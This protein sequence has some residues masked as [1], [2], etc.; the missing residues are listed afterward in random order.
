MQ[1]WYHLL[2]GE[3]HFFFVRP[4]AANLAVFEHWSTSLDQHERFLADECDECHKVGVTHKQRPKAGARVA[5]AEQSESLKRSSGSRS[6][7]AVGVAQAEQSES[8]K[9]SSRAARRVP[10]QG[11]AAP[12]NLTTAAHGQS[13]SPLQHTNSLTLPPPPSRL[14]LTALSNGS[15]QRRSPTALSNG[16][17][18][19]V[20][21]P[22]QTLFIPT[23]WLHAVFTPKDSLVFGGNFIHGLNCAGQLRVNKLEAFLKVPR[24]HR[25]LPPPPRRTRRRRSPG[26]AVAPLPAAI[27]RLSL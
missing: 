23:G 20:L 24:S 18:Q 1:V 26:A 22:G 14:S 9:R 21:L 16:S 4:T 6:T 27:Q 7:G 11:G 17:L 8:L 15:L 10:Q 13:N 19:V 12:D 3:K 2:R 25:P 5:Q